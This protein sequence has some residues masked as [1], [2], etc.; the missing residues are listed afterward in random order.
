LHDGVVAAVRPSEA[1]IVAYYEANIESYISPEMLTVTTWTVADSMLAKRMVRGLG[2]GLPDAVVLNMARSTDALLSARTVDQLRDQLEGLV[3]PV[4]R[5]DVVRV[6]RSS[7]SYVYRIEKEIPA[8]PLPFE[9]VRTSVQTELTDARAA[10][11]FDELLDA[12][13][14]RLEVQIDE[15][16]LAR[17]GL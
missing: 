8:A 5:G 4:E 13:R 17:V 16:A 10:E 14:A 11:A 3:G 2:T 1:E 12:V 7:L 6:T 9:K 15:A